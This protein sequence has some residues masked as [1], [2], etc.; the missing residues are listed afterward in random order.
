MSAL[1][2]QNEA[3]KAVK[4][5]RVDWDEHAKSDIVEELGVTGR[6]TLIMFNNKEEVGR[7]VADTSEDSIKPLFDA[8]V[9]N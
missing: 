2:E 5:L 9:G 1:I 3:F 8:V 7:V 4:I 6:S